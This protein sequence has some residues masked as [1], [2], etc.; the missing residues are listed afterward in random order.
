MASRA[1]ISISLFSPRSRIV[2]TPAARSVRRFI[3]ARKA[4]RASGVLYICS[5]S[6]TGLVVPPTAMW[7]WQSIMPGITVSLLQSTVSAPGGGSTSSGRPT[8]VIRSPSMTNTPSLIGAMSVAV[9]RI[10]L[11]I[12]LAILRPLLSPHH[13]MSS[14]S[15]P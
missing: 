3:L 13:S 10:L 6:G 5:V 11:R 1:T 4:R 2:V 8:C 7:T 15:S 12:T 14:Q 9:I